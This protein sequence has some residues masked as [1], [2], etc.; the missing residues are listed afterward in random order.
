MAHHYA[1]AHKEGLEAGL[2][3]EF[4]EL[5]SK[6]AGIGRA[7]RDRLEQRSCRCHGVVMNFRVVA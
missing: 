4:R 1:A 3:V 5:T 6:L 2:D 7:V